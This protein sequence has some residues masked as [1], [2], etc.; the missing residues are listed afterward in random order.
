MTLVRDR[1]RL[2]LIP[3]PA[4]LLDFDKASGRKSGFEENG[5][6]RL[7]ERAVAILAVEPSIYPAGLL[8]GFSQETSDRRWWVLYTKARQEKAV[9]RRLFAWEIPF[10]LPVAVKTNYSRGRRFSSRV[11]LFAGYVFLYASDEERVQ[12]LTTNRISRTLPVGAPMDLR[13]DLRQIESLIASGASLTLE[14]RLQPGRRVKVRLGPLRG[15]E[16]TILNRRGQTRLLVAVD[17]LK[18]GASVDIDDYMVEA[19]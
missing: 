9:A 13:D 5:H 17:F 10:Y 15:L 16:G 7:K 18:Q 11:P 12:S 1:E 19:I 6:S 4:L 8:N 3:T 14:S 2:S